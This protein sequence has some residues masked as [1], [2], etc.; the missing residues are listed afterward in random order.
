MS[1]YIK[2]I[3]LSVV[4]IALLTGNITPTSDNFYEDDNSFNEISASL[5]SGWDW[6]INKARASQCEDYTDDCVDVGG[7]RW[8]D[9]HDWGHETDA[10]RTDPNDEQGEGGYGD[11]DNG[12]ETSPLD[13]NSILS[14]LPSNC[15]SALKPTISANG[16]STILEIPYYNEYFLAA[17]NTHDVCY[18]QASSYRYACDLN[19]KVDMQS[20]CLT[21]RNR[22]D[23]RRC[24]SA[25]WTFYNGVDIAGSRF[26]TK[27]KEE[28]KC[29]DWH[30][31]KNDNSC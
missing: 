4:A 24:M 30:G 26:F 23:E 12:S 18:S 19:F 6:G 8:E 21:L 1:N 17:C 29:Y 25:S 9:P 13:C 3:S 11:G 5:N 20:E 15:N 7:T 28:R 2:N 27:A 16:C 10:D 14:N 22:G 31:L